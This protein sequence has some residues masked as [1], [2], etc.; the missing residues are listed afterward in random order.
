ME[1]NLDGIIPNYPVKITFQ[2]EFVR[3]KYYN[4]PKEPDYT[5]E[6]LDAFMKDD[7]CTKPRYYWYASSM[8]NFI[9]EKN[10]VHTNFFENMEY[11]DGGVLSFIVNMNG[12]SAKRRRYEL[13]DNLNEFHGK[14]FVNSLF[15]GDHG[16]EIFAPS[17][18]AYTDSELEEDEDDKSESESDEEDKDYE[19]EEEE[20]S[21]RSLGYIDFELIEC[22][23]IN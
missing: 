8:T 23:P 19:S 17:R 5:K 22:K 10:K 18:K 21:I 3:C 2:L 12:K 13:C 15:D 7:Y 9:Y 16:N 14:A 11:K 4:T 6:E 20:S 1:K